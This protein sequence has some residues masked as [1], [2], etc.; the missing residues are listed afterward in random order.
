MPECSAA[1]PSFYQ[2]AGPE[3]LEPVESA[4]TQSH[5]DVIGQSP[6]SNTESIDSLQNGAVAH[7]SHYSD[8][9]IYGVTFLSS[10]CNTKDTSATDIMKFRDDEAVQ[11]IELFH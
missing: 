11:N 6:T 4:A 10:N 3:M 8:I 2:V 5:G 7:S 1:R 9:H